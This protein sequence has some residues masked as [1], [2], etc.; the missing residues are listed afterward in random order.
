MGGATGALKPI[1]KRELIVPL[2]NLEPVLPPAFA[3]QEPF[4]F[5]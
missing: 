1:L 3:H 4:F 5:P 2:Q